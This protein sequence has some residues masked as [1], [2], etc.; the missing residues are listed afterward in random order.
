MIR[1]ITFAYLDETHDYDE[2]QSQKL[3]SSE[4]I[5]YTCGPAHTVAVHPGQQH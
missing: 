2:A 5:L 1:N 3:A 4:D